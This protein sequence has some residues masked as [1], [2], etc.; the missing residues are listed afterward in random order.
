M[1]LTLTTF[2]LKTLQAMKFQNH[3]KGANW[4]LVRR[5]ILKYVSVSGKMLPFSR[6]RNLQKK[7]KRSERSNSPKFF[8]YAIPSKFFP[9]RCNIY[10]KEIYHD[11]RSI[12]I[13]HERRISSTFQS[14]IGQ[15][16]RKKSLRVSNFHFSHRVF[17]PDFRGRSMHR[18]EKFLEHVDAPSPWLDCIHGPS[19]FRGVYRSGGGGGSHSRALWKRERLEILGRRGYY[20]SE[21]WREDAWHVSR[22]RENHATEKQ[23]TTPFSRFSFFLYSSAPLPFASPP[24]VRESKRFAWSESFAS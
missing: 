11:Q 20:E 10:I 24:P 6:Y 19:V 14:S 3:V 22:I 17:V 8:N 2:R 12:R 23:R 18:H 13:R 7:K 1:Q 9:L 5:N 21:R 16:R 15:K 4:Y